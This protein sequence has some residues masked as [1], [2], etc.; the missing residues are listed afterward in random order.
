[1]FGYYPDLPLLTPRRKTKYSSQCFNI[2][3]IWSENPNILLNLYKAFNLERDTMKCEHFDK[4]TVLLFRLK[5]SKIS[6]RFF[7]A[8]VSVPSGDREHS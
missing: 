3:F 8:T 4:G 1:M 5:I 2:L 6:G 7:Q